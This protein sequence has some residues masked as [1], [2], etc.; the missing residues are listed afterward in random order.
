MSTPDLPPP[1][2][3]APDIILDCDRLQAILPHR[4][5]LLM[6]DRVRLLPAERR[7]IGLKTVTINE[8]HFQGHFPGNPILPGVLILEAL[9]QTGAAL[10]RQCLHVEREFAYLLTLDN[11]K[12]RKPVRPGDG[13]LTD[14]VL[15]RAARGIIKCAGTAAVN[16]QQVCQA[17][18]SLGL[19]PPLP[20]AA[21]PEAFDPPLYSE[22]FPIAWSTLADVTAVMNIIPHRYPFMLVD[23]IFHKTDN[24]VLGLKNVSRN[25]P[26]FNGHFQDRPIMPGT[27]LVEAIA[28]VGAAF[29]LGKPENQGKLGFFMAV[30]SA[31][32]RR[33]VRPGDRL[34]IDV[35]HTVARPR[36]GKASG[37]I[38]VGRQPAVDADISFVIVDR[39]APA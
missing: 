27:L 2:A 29:I 20:E 26:F 22:D 4:Y 14:V 24:R 31:R 7:A 36:V 1:Q 3:A 15:A 9:L 25:E 5:P 28:Q 39:P 8:P 17:S 10:I 19:A 18:F 13:L 35:R 37:R 32:F 21:T 34:L 38:W 23:A 16:G 11:V 12:F 6:L 33:P 30:E